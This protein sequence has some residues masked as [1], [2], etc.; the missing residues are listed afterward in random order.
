MANRCNGVPLRYLRLKCNVV[1]MVELDDRTHSRSKDKIRD[2]RLQRAA[3]LPA[4]VVAQVT[5]PRLAA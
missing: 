4:G 2:A 3:L 5:E 1:A